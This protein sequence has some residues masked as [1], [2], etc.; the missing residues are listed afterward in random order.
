LNNRCLYEPLQVACA[1]WVGTVASDFVV[2]STCEVA[3]GGVIF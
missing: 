3:L 2:A 1:R